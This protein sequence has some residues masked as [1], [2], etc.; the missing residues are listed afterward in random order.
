MDQTKLLEEIRDILRQSADE[1]RAERAEIR[2]RVNL[3]LQTQL[4]GARFY[5]RVVAVGAVLI[6]L[7]IVL[8][9]SLSAQR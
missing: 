4:A 6:G 9:F 8:M 3:S 5:R 7:L 2:E 1:T